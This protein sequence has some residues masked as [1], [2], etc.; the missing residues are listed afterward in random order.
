M[1]L[2]DICPAG[3]RARLRGHARRLVLRALAALAA[4]LCAAVAL[5]LASFAAFLAI[6]ER[7]GRL[8]AALILAAFYALAAILIAILATRCP[9]SA[10]PETMDAPPPDATAAGS[11]IAALLAAA[12]TDQAALLAMATKLGRELTPLQLM[13]A[14]LIGGVISGR[15]L[16]R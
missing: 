14:A 13:L 15:T 1:I 3:F 4:A 12:G 11:D 9:R 6:A 2:S 10:P 5:G 7:H 16:G 8:D